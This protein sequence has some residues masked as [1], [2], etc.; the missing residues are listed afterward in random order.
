M[1]INIGSKKA[2]GKEGGEINT[3]QPGYNNGKE[4][5]KRRQRK[6]IINALKSS[7]G[8][9]VHSALKVRGDLERVCAL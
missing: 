7:L 1:L 5:I 9:K 6:Q 2:E 8:G 3:V 4:L